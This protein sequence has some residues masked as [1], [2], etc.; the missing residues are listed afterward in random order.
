ME[1]IISAELTA[2]AYQYSLST[3]RHHIRA[4]NKSNET[5]KTANLEAE[6][7]LESPNG[8]LLMKIVLW[9]T[10]LSF[11]CAFA[12]DQ[13]L[14]FSTGGFSFQFSLGTLVAFAVGVAFGLLFW[15]LAAGGKSGIL[16]AMALMIFVGLGLFLYPMRFVQ[17][18]HLMEVAV[19]L[20][21][22]VFAL[23]VLGFLTL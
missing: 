16:K 3:V 19:G 23:S 13:A 11:G 6:R 4:V 1:I 8:R 10:A 14:Q 17:T 22:A 2:P 12:S 5:M 15:R 7:E 18:R 20:V 9:S 21:A